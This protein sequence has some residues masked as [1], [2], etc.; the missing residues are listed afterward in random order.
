MTRPSGS[1]RR[2]TAF[3][4]WLRGSRAQLG[5]SRKALASKAGLCPSTLRNIE[6]GRHRMQSWTADQL[7]RTIEDLDPA[8]RRTAP[9]VDETAVPEPPSFI[10]Q[11]E[12]KATPPIAV[13]LLFASVGAQLQMELE[14]DCATV[15][16]LSSLL[17]EIAGCASSGQRRTPVAIQIVAFER[18]TA[19]LRSDRG[20][21]H[22]ADCKAATPGG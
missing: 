12:S 8:L 2:Y 6:K 18:K 5:L 7:L 14:L 17:A 20:A 9:S 10:S 21:A 3:G 19:S 1:P 11:P 4:L 16:Q 13:Q 15:I 22:G